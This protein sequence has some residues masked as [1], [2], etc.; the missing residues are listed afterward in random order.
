MNLPKKLL[1]S[2]CV[3]ITV[4]VSAQTSETPSEAKYLRDPMPES[5]QMTPETTQSLPT[6]DEW[7]HT[8]YDPMLDRLIAKTVEN[9]FDVAAAVKRIDMARNVLK[10][11]EAGYFP[12][13]SLSGGYTYSQQSGAMSKP[14]GPSSRSSSFSLGA[15]MNWEIDLFGRI[16]A[17]ANAQKIAVNVARADYN[18]V[19]VSLC[20]KVATAYMELRVCQ[21]QLAVNRA[22]I[23]SQ[24]KVVKITE[25]RFEA[26]LADMLDVTQARTVLYNTQSTLPGIQSKIR[27]LINTL[28]I[29]VGEYPGALAEDLA[30]ETALPGYN[31]AIDTGVPT[32]I[33]RRRPDIQ[34]AE[35]TL[36]Q[37][38][39]QIG[40][41]KKDFLPTLSLA[42]SIG[43]GARRAGDL[44]GDHSMS[45]SIAPQLSWTLFD[46]LARNYRVAEAKLQFETAIDS[47]NLTVMNAVGEVDN[48][49]QEYDATLK[50][51]ELQ[52]KVV[53]QSEKAL[54][55]AINLYKTG[56]TAFSN[57]VDGQMSWL[58]SQN[59]LVS[60]EGEALTS[61]ITIYQAL[62]GGWQSQEYHINK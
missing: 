49:L 40:I 14:V 8:F 12:T 18:A 56:L 13:I 6:D 57:V 36:A 9:N 52:E 7:W 61:L 33:L 1:L 35:M 23:S 4:S 11:T 44:F 24:E 37:Y 2:V 53:E 50:S 42:G 31:I 34:Q 55:L 47:Y 28:S 27:T 32:D 17:N 5:W 39:A 22:H 43:T 19:M 51:I 45:Y 54:R 62:G 20:A 29:L 10:E 25:A 38:A 16:R 3:G 30:V 59:Q 26:E 21:K 46:G 48:A 60:L 58:T 41:A 15:N